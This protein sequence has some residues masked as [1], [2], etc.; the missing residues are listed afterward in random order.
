MSELI[1][2]EPDGP[3]R[4]AFAA[5][6]LAQDPPLQTATAS[7]WLVPVDL[8]ASVPAEVLEGAYVDGFLVGSTWVQDTL[9]TVLGPEA[10]ATPPTLDAPGPRGEELPDPPTDTTA[11]QLRKRRT[12]ASARK[13]A[14]G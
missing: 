13:A 12:R 11:T 9:D 4:P 10:P 5:W 6:G 3:H 14:D 8:Y 1:L 2:I 7:G